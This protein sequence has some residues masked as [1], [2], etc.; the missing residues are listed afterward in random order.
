MNMGPLA[1][2]P[3]RKAR[4]E[5]V[6]SL[7][8]EPSVGRSAASF[9]NE[10][11]SS[12]H[13]ETFPCM[14]WSPKALGRKDPTSTVLPSGVSLGSSRNWASD[15]EIV[16]PNAYRVVVPALAAYSH[17]ASVGSR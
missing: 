12:T 7:R 10:K 17:S 4:Y 5:Q 13:S 16:S 1:Y 8:G 9:M 2:P 14:S 11:Q 15:F 6:P 3:P